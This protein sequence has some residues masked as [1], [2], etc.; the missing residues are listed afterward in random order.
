V[1][2]LRIVC[3]GEPFRPTEL[4]RIFIFSTPAYWP[5]TYVTL[6]ADDGT[7]HAITNVTRVAW[8]CAQGNEPAMARLDFEDVDVELEAE[9]GADDAVARDAVVEAA[10]AWA[11][12]DEGALTGLM[13]ALERVP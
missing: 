12:G 5:D 1:S 13:K 10:R 2:R 6:I 8:R 3:K 4:G 7:E 11:R 9:F